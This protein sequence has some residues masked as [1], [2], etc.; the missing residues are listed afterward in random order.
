MFA[1]D[2]F[3]DLAVRGA[4]PQRLLWASTSTKDPAYADVKYVEALIGPETVNTLP[5]KTLD[6]YRDHGRPA[7][8]LEEPRGARAA[9]VLADLAELGIDLDQ[10]TA[11]LIEEGVEKFNKPYDELIALPGRAPHRRRE[12]P[13]RGP[14]GPAHGGGAATWGWWR[15]RAPSWPRTTWPRASGAGTPPSGP[16]TPRLPR[17]IAGALGWLDVAATMRD[18]LG[19]IDDFVRGVRADGF[20][21]VVHVGMGGSSMTPLV[22]TRACPGATAPPR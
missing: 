3:G 13:G 20:T 12:R 18:R 9:R 1:P 2:A 15:R 22:L 10:V 17:V 7:R 21:H 16:T 19:E 6:A 14:G 8:R 4:R 5:G 11:Q